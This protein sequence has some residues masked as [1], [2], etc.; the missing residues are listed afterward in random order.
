MEEKE[1]NITPIIT[2]ILYFLLGVLFIC[3]TEELIKTFNYILICVCAVI[4]VVQI[5]SNIFNKDKKQFNLIIGIIFIWA[6]LILYANYG[7]NIL[8]ILFSLYLF[9]ITANFFQKAKEE[10]N[11]KWINIIFGIGA[12][13]TGLL[14]I[15]AKESAIFTYLKVTGVYLII[16]AVY[17]LIEY[18]KNYKK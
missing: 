2:N 3:T 5:I 1:R 13:I 8:P 6:A 11:T 12:V 16:V 9:I 14:L 10:K 7:Y 4:G 15:F 17:P 18:I